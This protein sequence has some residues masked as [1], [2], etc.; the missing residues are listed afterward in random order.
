MVRT[1]YFARS[2]KEKH[3][4]RLRLSWLTSPHALPLLRFNPFIDD[5]W[6]SFGVAATFSYDRIY[7][8]D[9]E[10]EIAAAASRLATSRLI[11]AAFSGKGQVTY[12]DDV[13]CWFDMGIVS[14]HG[15]EHADKLKKLNTRGHA[16]IFAEIFEVPVPEP[17]FWGNAI[18]EA[19]TGV[20]QTSEGYHL[21]VNAFAGGRWP[22]KQFPQYE[23]PVLLGC[24]CDLAPDTT[25]I[26]LV[27]ADDDR[28]KNEKLMDQLKR[29]NLR[30]LVTD[31][32]VLRLAAAIRQMDFLISSDSLALH[33]GIAQRVPF[34]AFFSP[35][36]AAEIDDF[37]LGLKLES[38]APDY[39]SYRADA[40]N[41]T[42][43]TARMLEAL[44]CHP[45]A[46]EWCRGSATPGA[47]NK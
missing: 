14:R 38:T 20:R 27:G 24:L 9:D 10:Q 2:L 37:G 19:A 23:L 34:L 35:T 6:T 36:S 45:A 18:L 30:A 12:S 40:D 1:S 28:R 21:A 31:D 44:K 4:G 43:T 33:L 29:S 3:G 32:S 39:C 47:S 13:S 41:S 8:L 15:K 16:E 17:S 42:I 46:P 25:T 22:S 26:W 7:S 5:V 11:G